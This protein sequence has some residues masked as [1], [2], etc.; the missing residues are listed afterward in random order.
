MFFK[1]MIEIKNNNYRIEIEKF[2]LILEDKFCSIKS[3]EKFIK[4]QKLNEKTIEF[5]KEFYEKYIDLKVKFTETINDYKLYDELLKYIS[6]QCGYSYKLSRDFKH[7]SD[8]MKKGIYHELDVT[9]IEKDIQ[10]ILYII[11][12]YD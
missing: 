11:N 3:K 4:E 5:L 8:N 12:L 7:I 9:E 2:N 1:E 6:E 10:N